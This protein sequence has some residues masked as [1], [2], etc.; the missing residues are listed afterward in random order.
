[1]DPLIVLLLPAVYRR[2][3]FARA[4]GQTPSELFDSSPVPAFAEF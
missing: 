4:A 1:M 2:A 3:D